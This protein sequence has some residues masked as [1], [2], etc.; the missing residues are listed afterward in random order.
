VKRR[1]L[2]A[3]GRPCCPLTADSLAADEFA[4]KAPLL[5]WATIARFQHL[6]GIP[7]PESVRE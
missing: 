4:V 6:R 2:P 5:A 7:V 1:S 3:S